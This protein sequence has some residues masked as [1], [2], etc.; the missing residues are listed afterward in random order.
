MKFENETLNKLRFGLGKLFE[1]YGIE[2]SMSFQLGKITYAEDYAN[3]A[4]KVY[5]KDENTNGKES[6]FRINASRLSVPLEWYNKKVSLNGKW[7]TISGIN[8]RAR[9]YPLILSCD[10]GSSKKTTVASIRNNIII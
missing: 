6:E 2:N 4:V 10:D 1:S 9:K 5:I 8:M 7:Y 3:F